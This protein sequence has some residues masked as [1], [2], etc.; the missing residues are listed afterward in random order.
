ML[1]NKALSVCR[2][3]KENRRKYNDKNN[4]MKNKRKTE[5]FLLHK[6]CLDIV[7][8]FIVLYELFNIPS[9]TQHHT[10]QPKLERWRNNKNMQY[11]ILLRSPFLCKMYAIG[12]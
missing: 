9:I 4:A 10:L 6:D 12:I 8:F 11:N 3:R 7:L 5:T 1:L 2:Y